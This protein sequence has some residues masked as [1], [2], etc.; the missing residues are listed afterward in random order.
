MSEIKSIGVFG[1]SA[2]GNSPVY[3]DGAVLLGQRLAQK[4]IVM[5]YGA[6]QSGVIGAAA[7]SCLAEGGTVVGYINDYLLEREL[8]RFELTKV[9]QF[10][11]MH[12][13]KD[14][15]YAA[16]DAFCVLPGGLG[17]LDE[18]SEI[19]VLKQIGEQNKPVFFYNKNGFWDD[20]RNCVNA[21]I[22]NNFA[23]EEDAFLATYTDDIDRIFAELGV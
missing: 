3:H 7:K 1:G 15:M 5:N 23:Q 18:A 21:L 22:Q 11:S 14:A 20:F 17:T 6:G 13:R 10:A 12:E 4:G 2:M 9:Y 16:S 8:Q 19:L